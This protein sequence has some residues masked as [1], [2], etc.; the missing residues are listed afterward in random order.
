[1]NAVSFQARDTAH[2]LQ[3]IHSR[4]GA[5]AVVL[6][7]GRVPA[8]G[9]S[10]LWRRPQLEIL[11]GVPDALPPPPPPTPVAKNIGQTDNYEP[12]DAGPS[13]LG[14]AWRSAGVL[15]QLGLLPL[16]VDQVLD[17][18]RSSHG[19]APPAS[20]LDEFA[21]V[22]SALAGFWRAPSQATNGSPGIHVFIGP[23]GSGKT[24]ALCKWLA[25]SV[26]AEG[27]SARAW[28]LDGRAA[29]FAGLLDVYGE[30]LG[31]PVD[32][33]WRANQTTAGF[34]V[35]FVDLPGLEAQDASAVEQFRGRL[36]TMAPAQIHLVLNAAYDVS[37][38]LAQARAFSAL[39]VSDVIF[40]HLDEEKRPAK[41]W[42]VL[43]GTN[44]TVRFLS[45]GQNIPGDFLSASAELLI[46]RQFRA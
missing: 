18:A 22:R 6:S 14:G 39:P 24:T 29:N 8:S 9:F 46:P 41:L 13:G 40:T 12:A 7:V 4:L 37:V 20:L 5:D 3:Q 21:L 2:A 17:R 27:R 15:H 16:Y 1:M 43:L 26:L 35:G 23:P 38:L 34:E 45:G 28:R 42:N 25:K 11:A 30:I 33:E 19:D 10:R 31:V 44:F 32:R 36:G